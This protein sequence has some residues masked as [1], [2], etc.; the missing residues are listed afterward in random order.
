MVVTA[1]V[2]LWNVGVAYLVGLVL[3]HAGRRG[4]VRLGESP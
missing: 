3:H 1:G 2:A 4:L